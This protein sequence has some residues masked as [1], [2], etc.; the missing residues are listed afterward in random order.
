M[1][2]TPRDYR[3]KGLYNLVLVGVPVVCLDRL[4]MCGIKDEKWTLLHNNAWQC[5]ERDSSLRVGGVISVRTKNIHR[6]YRCS[7][8]VL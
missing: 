6:R 7:L 4:Y 8:Y 3:L 5:S 2:N 1:L